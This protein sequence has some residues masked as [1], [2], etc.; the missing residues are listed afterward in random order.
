MA[1]N[2]T[3]VHT[4]HGLDLTLHCT[5]SPLAVQ[6]MKRVHLLWQP[7]ETGS[8]AVWCLFEGLQFILGH[9][10]CY[11]QHFAWGTG[12]NVMHGYKAAAVPNMF[13]EECQSRPDSMCTP[14]VV[15]VMIRLPVTAL[16]HC[17]VC[18]QPCHAMR[19]R[20]R[21]LA[22]SQLATP[23]HGFLSTCQLAAA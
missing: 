21:C 11:D 6:S 3:V 15:L 7:T 23:N 18:F 8:E 9:Q 22:H 14:H 17:I 16:S 10:C 13:L 20:H 19:R 1:H 2:L 4:Q 5:A 12:S